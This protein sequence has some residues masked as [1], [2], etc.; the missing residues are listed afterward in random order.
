MTGPLV[1]P[2]RIYLPLVQL[3]AFWPVLIWYARRTVDGSDDAW[4]VIALIAAIAVLLRGAGTRD[5]PATNDTSGRSRSAG[6]ITL[7]PAVVLTLVYAIAR[8]AVPGGLPPLLMAT[9]A[10]LALSLT[11]SAV[12]F[13][14][15]LHPAL[16]GLLLLSLPIV[17]SLQFY[18]GYP[19]RRV[20][21]ELA[22]VTL[23]LTPLS[24]AEDPVLAIGVALRVAGRTIEVDAP[25]SGLRML[26]VAG[27]LVLS[28]GCIR[29]ITTWRLLVGGALALIIVVLANGQRAAALVLVEGMGARAPK[30]AHAAVGLAAFLVVLIPVIWI[31]TRG[32]SPPAPAS[33]AGE[34]PRGRRPFLIACALAAAAPLLSRDAAPSDTGPF[35]G[36]PASLD[37]RTLS[38]LPLSPR[39]EVFADAFPGEVARFHD[40][41]GE[42][43]L[44]YVTAP[45][46]RLHP[47]ADCFRGLG[48]EIGEPELWKDEAG[49]EWRQFDAERDRARLRVHERIHDAA[50]QNFT[51]LSSWYWAALLGRTRGPWWSVVIAR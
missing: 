16:T 28:I 50:G 24:P 7:F 43:V 23:S 10:V 35:P 45:T 41:L 6:A 3:L 2:S 12:V 46:R 15:V 18:V 48:Y 29:R 40:G 33:R 1:R 11:A 21:S 36:W 32:A 4:G 9:L 51:D 30:W 25:C 38:R 14:R 27:F 13:D 26:W 17:A 34:P 5:A 39:E 37:G 49:I 42:V 22:A 47:A 44:R 8:C 19:L 20:A 31:M